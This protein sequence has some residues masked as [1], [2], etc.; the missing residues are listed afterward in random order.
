MLQRLAIQSNKACFIDI[1]IPWIVSEHGYTTTIQGSFPN[2]SCHL[3]HL[4]AD[5]LLAEELDLKIDMN[6]PRVWNAMQ[7][8]NFNFNLVKARC[9]L[10]FDYKNFFMGS[11]GVYLGGDWASG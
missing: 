6:Y 4:S 3:S 8:W 7:T 9:K 1:D 10:V 11:L 5:F 2:S